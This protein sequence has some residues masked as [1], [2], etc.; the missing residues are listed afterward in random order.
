LP[1]LREPEDPATLLGESGAGVEAQESQELV[2]QTCPSLIGFSI[3]ILDINP[4]FEPQEPEKTRISPNSSTVLDK[5]LNMS[6]LHM[7][8]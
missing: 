4:I 8:I 2:Q 7:F 3:T 5:L 1:Q 6:N